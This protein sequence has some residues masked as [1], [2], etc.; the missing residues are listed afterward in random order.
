MSILKSTIG[1][2]GENADDMMIIFRVLNNRHALSITSQF[3]LQVMYTFDHF[4][5]DQ[6]VALSEMKLRYATQ[7]ILNIL[8]DFKWDDVTSQIKNKGIEFDELSSLL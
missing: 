4:D 2:V 8:P 6:N 3:R 1:I 5:N 7:S